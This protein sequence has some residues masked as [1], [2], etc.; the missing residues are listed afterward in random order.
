M[1]RSDPTSGS[2]RNI[3]FFQWPTR[4]ADG[5][6]LK[7]SAPHAEARYT[8]IPGSPVPTAMWDSTVMYFWYFPWYRFLQFLSMRML[9]HGAHL[10]PREQSFSLAGAC[11][12]LVGQAS[13]LQALRVLYAQALVP[14]H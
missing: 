7:E 12:I 10:A 4:L 9:P 8:P 5:L 6:G 14:C 2:A 13:F 3:T 1:S 11:L